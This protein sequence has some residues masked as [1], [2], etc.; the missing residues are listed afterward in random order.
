MSV[1]RRNAGLEE[2]VSTHLGH[3]TVTARKGMRGSFVMIRCLMIQG[4]THRY[5]MNNM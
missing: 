5:S 2:R 4:M 3:T 1:T